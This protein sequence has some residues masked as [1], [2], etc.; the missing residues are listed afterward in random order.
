MISQHLMVSHKG[1]IHNTRKG[2]IFFRFS[3]MTFRNILI[4]HNYLLTRSIPTMEFYM[5]TRSIPCGEI[6]IW[7]LLQCWVSLLPPPTS[8]KTQILHKLMHNLFFCCQII[9]QFSKEH[10]NGTA[11]L[12]GKFQNDLTWNRHYRQT[13]FCKIWVWGDF[14][15]EGYPIL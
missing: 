8:L 11:V 3:K 13:I 7:E 12:C 14:W 4:R 10:S 9:L 15:R 5:Q 2:I 6:D 1:F